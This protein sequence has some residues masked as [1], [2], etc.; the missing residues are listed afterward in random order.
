MTTSIYPLTYSDEVYKAVGRCIMQCKSTEDLITQ[1]NQANVLNFE[2]KRS[3]KRSMAFIDHMTQL[4][5]NVNH[6]A[7]SVI[8]SS[9]L[10][11]M[12]D[13][14]WIEDKYNGNTS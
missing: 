3:D 4:M 13:H 14:H 9:A 5:D 7:Y 11:H 12:P 2:L 10:E 6:P 1:L 8:M